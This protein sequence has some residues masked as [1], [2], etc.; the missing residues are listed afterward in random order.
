MGEREALQT[1][2]DLTKGNRGSLAYMIY[3]MAGEALRVRDSAWKLPADEMP[4]LHN[5]V[6]VELREGAGQVCDVACYIGRFDIDGGGTEDRWILADVRLDTRQ[7]KRWAH[8]Y[9][10]PPKS[11][12]DAAVAEEHEQTKRWARAY[13]IAHDQAMANGGE[14]QRLRAQ[15]AQYENGKD[16]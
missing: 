4:P 2:Y 8:I 12:I 16:A 5:Q 3:E 9:P 1:I 7:I 14:V 6:L 13:E 15:L 10:S 11:E